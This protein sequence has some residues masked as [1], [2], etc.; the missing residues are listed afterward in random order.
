MTYLKNILVLLF[1]FS[2]VFYFAQ[3]QDSINKIV[4][5]QIQEVEIKAKKKLIERK[6][7]RLV[8]N[9]ENS[10][11]AQGGDAMDILKIVPGIK[12]QNDKITMVGKGRILV[13]VNDRPIQISG[14]DLAN[15]LKT[16]K[17]DEIEKIEVMSNPPAKYTAEG[18]SGVLNII[19]K[20]TK[21]NS[22]NGNL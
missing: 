15:Y 21:K 16:L 14:D 4:E 3:E 17:S 19:T 9:V 12:V 18:N 22:W 11:A 6:V 8:Y 5:K 13:L 10:V 1:V 7:D 2:Y 20:T